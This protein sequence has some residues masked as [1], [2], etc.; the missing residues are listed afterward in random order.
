MEAQLFELDCQAMFIS[1]R[2][3][4]LPWR[5]PIF[6]D[7]EQLSKARKWLEEDG[8]PE[9]VFTFHNLKFYGEVLMNTIKDVQVLPD[10][11]EKTNALVKKMLS[12]FT[13][14]TLTY[15]N[16]S[17]FREVKDVVN[18]WTHVDII[19]QNENERRIVLEG[20]RHVLERTKAHIEEMIVEWKRL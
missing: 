20:E 1:D 10:Y 4:S 19:A 11:I 8:A 6:L 15:D 16:E 18:G 7:F 5:E 3:V 9:E 17:I 12:E 14:L 13:T 2:I